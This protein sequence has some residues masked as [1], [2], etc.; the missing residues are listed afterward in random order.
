[1]PDLI[2]MPNYK[3]YI[4]KEDLS[5][6]IATYLFVETSHETSTGNWC[7]SDEEIAQFFDITI[8][9]VHELKDQIVKDLETTYNDMVESVDT[10]MDG[11]LLMF[12][13]NLWHHAIYGLIDDDAC[14]YV[15]EN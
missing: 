15:P 2:Y 11:E 8:S 9:L 14:F 10:Y 13:L 5:A 6:K 4:T 7:T 1:M 3:R 12:D